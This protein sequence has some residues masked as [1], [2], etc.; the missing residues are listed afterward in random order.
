MELE[1]P[2]IDIS[3]RYMKNP[4]NPVS[5]AKPDPENPNEP[6]MTTERMTQT[7]PGNANIMMD[8]KLRDHTFNDRFLSEYNL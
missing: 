2:S 8:K 3:Q 5:P 6:L 4:E 1:F 7:K